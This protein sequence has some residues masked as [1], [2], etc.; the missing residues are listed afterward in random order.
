MI[1][2]RYIVFTRYFILFLLIIF[3]LNGCNLFRKSVSGRKVQT[4][5]ESVVRKVISAQPEW[6]FIEIRLTGKAEEDKS[7]LSF[8]GTVK[9]EKNRQIFIL[10]RSPIGIEIARVYANLDSV[11][12]VSKMLNIKQK[13][14][15]KLVERKIGYPVDFYALQGILVQSLFTSSGNQVNKLIEGLVA[16]NEKE[17]LRLVSNTALQAEGK[18]IKYYNDFLIN[19]ESYIIEWEKIKDVNGQWIAE[20]NFVYNKENIIKKI[21]LKGMDSERNFAVEANI[22]KMEIKEN[23]EIKFDKF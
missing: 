17:K 12:L 20:V 9:M 2:N 13:V 15:W 16:T 11:W 19:M 8:M 7:R 23:I 3:T 5:D 18:N 21:E 6:N 1:E 10:L 14:E 4:E 22:I